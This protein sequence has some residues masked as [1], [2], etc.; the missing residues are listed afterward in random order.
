[1]G[2]IVV[3]HGYGMQS[4]DHWYPYLRD[5]LAAQGHEVRVPQLPDPLAPSADAWLKTLADEVSA[6]GVPAAGTVL[7][8]HSLGG[9]NVLRLLAGH[10]TETEGPYAGVV[11]VASMAGEVGYDALASFFDPG[12]DWARIRR[13]AT[14]FRVLHA[15]DDPVT[16]AATSEHIMRFVTELG[17]TATVTATGGH[18]PSTGD[19]RPRLPEAARLVRELLGA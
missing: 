5:E 17:A 16:G 4:G 10:D 19:S 12:F 15:A 18:F 3:S 8:G 14:S 6:S 2:T 13:A 7:V 1:M 11:L 9:V